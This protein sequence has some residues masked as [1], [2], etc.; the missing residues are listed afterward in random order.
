MKL[1]YRIYSQLRA[2]MRS[3]TCDNKPSLQR[4][5]LLQMLWRMTWPN[6]IKANVKMQP[7]M[8]MMDMNRLWHQL[9]FYILL[10]LLK[11]DRHFH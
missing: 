3:L 5:A 10:S 1:N 9:K 4:M 11:K 7:Q 2:A 8:K 6:M